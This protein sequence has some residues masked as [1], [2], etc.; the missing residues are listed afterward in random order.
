VTNPANTGDLESRW[1]SLSDQEELNGETFLDDAWRMLRR[2]ITTIVADMAADTTGDLQAEVVRVMATAVLRVMMNPEGKR[3]EAIDD[4]S[5]T[6]DQAVSAG[7][8]Y[9]TDDELNALI[10]DG[11]G[12]S[13]A[14]SF[15]L[16]GT[17]YP[18]A[19]F[20]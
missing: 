11:G 12:P 5:W 15:S 14:F 20:P 6:R 3:Q 13:G 8:L 9:F 17:N 7:L 10:A 18:T 1:R 4:Y 16:L 19:R 2:R